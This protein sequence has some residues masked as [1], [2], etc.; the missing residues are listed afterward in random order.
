MKTLAR[1][2]DKAAILSRIEKLRPESPGRW[3][4][5]TAHQMVCHL[6]DSLRMA[7]GEKS[8]TA[9]SVPLPR[10]MLR[11]IVLYL[12]LPWPAGI[13]TSPELDQE[14]AGTPPADFAADVAQTVR[15]LETV[16]APGSRLH[17]RPHP[18]FG[19]MS[20]GAWL[21]WGYLHADHHLRQFGV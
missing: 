14:R 15:L 10:T 13:E 11:W 16:S 19:Q 8:A 21:R 6:A 1:P 18:A 20:D 12:P 17:E 7:V 3:G 9:T 2:S 5:M 4:R